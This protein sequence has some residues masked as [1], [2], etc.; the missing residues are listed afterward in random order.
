MKRLTV[1]DHL[2]LTRERAAAIGFT[3]EGTLYGVPAWLIEHSPE[4]V[5]GCPKIPAL[6][7]WTILADAAY[8]LA[9][10]FMREDQALESPIRILRPLQTGA[11]S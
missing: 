11:A 7:L 6:Q 8:E 4:V 2:Y 1:L 3:H 9:S 5:F 10:F